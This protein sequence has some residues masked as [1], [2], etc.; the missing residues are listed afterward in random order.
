M[1]YWLI[2]K[3]AF[4]TLWRTLSHTCHLTFFFTSISSGSKYAFII[5]VRLFSRVDTAKLYADADNYENC[6]TFQL[7]AISE[8]YFD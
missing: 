6:K 3:L 1:H 8:L 4:D 5:G 7:G 2:H